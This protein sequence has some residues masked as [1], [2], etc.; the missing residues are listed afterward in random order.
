LKLLHNLVAVVL[1]LLACLVFV[2][3][4]IST[5]FHQSVLVT[6]RFVGMVTE[7]TADP[8]VI[9]RL[10]TQISVQVVD[11]MEIQSRIENL[12]P[13][14]L[15]L[16]AIPITTAVQERIAESAARL[17]ASDRVQA[18]WD[19]ALTVLH[20]RLVA[21]LRGEAENVELVNGTLTIDVLAIVREVVAEL[22]AEGILPV[23]TLPDLNLV[24]NRQEFIDR[25]GAAVQVQLPPD[26]GQVQI[27]NA[28]RLQRVSTLV[29][30]SDA[31]IA[32]LFIAALILIVLTVIWAH[33]RVRAV[34]MIGLGIE[35]V[36]VMVLLLLAGAQG[37]A[38][39]SMASPDGRPVLA[40]FVSTAA[41]SL[42]MW[43]IWT[44]VIVALATVVIGIVGAVFG[45][46]R[47][48]PEEDSP[49][50]TAA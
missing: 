6:D 21:V 50:A 34:F 46:R 23:A 26:F 10:S 20:D 43:L 13:D 2:F 31:A 8:V 27:A 45:S 22:Q 1:G 3:A 5:W 17:L 33:R 7:V 36:L 15:D 16:V 44:G 47:S 28:D 30:T 29:Q 37:V 12:L 39:D 49:T 18:G 11:R 48:P 32:V 14:G 4:V 25:L 40:A 19:S 35:V 38:T 24:E 42:S 9:E 41:E